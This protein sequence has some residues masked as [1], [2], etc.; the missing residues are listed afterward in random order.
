MELTEQTLLIQL[1]CWYHQELKIPF[2]HVV[3][4]MAFPPTVFFARRNLTCP[5]LKF[6]PIP[7]SV[8]TVTTLRSIPLRIISLHH[9]HQSFESCTHMAHCDKAVELSACSISQRERKQAVI[10]SLTS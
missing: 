8:E 1:K 3:C 10:S 5:K 4:E 9:W 6:A 7:V 2:L